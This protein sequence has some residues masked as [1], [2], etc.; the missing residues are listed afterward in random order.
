MR[1]GVGLEILEWTSGT[2][3]RTCT[4]DWAEPEPAGPDEALSPG[5]SY[6]LPCDFT[7]LALTIDLVV[8]QEPRCASRS[9]ATPRT[10]RSSVIGASHFSPL[11][12]TFSGGEGTRTLGLYIANGVWPLSWPGAFR[13]R[14]GRDD[15]RG[16]PKGTQ[17]RG[18]ATVESC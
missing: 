18:W 7:D 3:F 10:W 5:K 9:P 16:A 6:A 11:N 17:G 14:A 4:G 8:R 2:E 12:R 15:D 1:T 13:E